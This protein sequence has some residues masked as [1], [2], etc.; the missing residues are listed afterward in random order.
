MRAILLLAAIAMLVVP[1]CGQDHARRE[2]AREVVD[3]FLRAFENLDMQ[4]FIDCFAE[5]ATVFFPEPEP[6]K[7][8]DGKAAI[9]AHFEL[10][11]AAIRRGSTSSQA[12]FHRLVPENVEVQPVG[13]EG[14]VVSF[15]LSNAVRIARR[16]VVL[17]KRGDSWL[18]VHLHASNVP[19]KEPSPVP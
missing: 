11:F 1:A 18:I 13:D 17:Q 14:A 7:R 10:V 9:K 5:D 16:T 6:A 19:V 3:R 8:F 12:P 15:E 2:E 4:R